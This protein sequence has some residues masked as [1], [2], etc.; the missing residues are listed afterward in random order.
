[1]R[2]EVNGF[3][4]CRCAKSRHVSNGRGM[5]GCSDGIL[6]QGGIENAAACIDSLVNSPA[7]R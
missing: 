1:M 4:Q 7:L 2:A 6:M 5:P 3:C